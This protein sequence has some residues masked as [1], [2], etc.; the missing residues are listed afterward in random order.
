V[1]WIGAGFLAVGGICWYRKQP[2][3]RRERIRL[4]A[5]E[6]GM[7]LLRQ[8]GAAA[9]LVN[10]GHVRLRA[11]VVPMPEHRS[12]ASAIVR[13]LALSSE[14]L[15]AEQLAKRLDPS[16]RPPVADLRAFLRAHDD[17]VFDQV[18]RGGFVLGSHYQLPD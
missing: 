7:N 17:T 6:I 3:E 14:S 2:G 11:S 8:A 12:I 1:A 15:S 16:L 13:E 5:G 9:E 18:R 4:V 10:N